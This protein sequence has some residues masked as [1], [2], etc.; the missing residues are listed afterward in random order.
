MVLLDFDSPAAHQPQRRGGRRETNKQ[1]DGKRLDN[2]I[3]GPSEESLIG[4]GRRPGVSRL[5]NAVHLATETF[6]YAPEGVKEFKTG[7]DRRASWGKDLLGR[8]LARR[9]ALPIFSHLPFKEGID[10]FHPW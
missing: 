3:E 9:L 2:C 4:H 5:G 1:A 10:I 6:P 7:R 8:W